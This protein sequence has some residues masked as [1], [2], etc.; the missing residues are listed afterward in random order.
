[1]VAIVILVIIVIIIVLFVKASILIV[2]IIVI[3][4]IIYYQ[5]FVLCALAK[6]GSVE[7]MGN[8]I[9]FIDSMLQLHIICKKKRN[10]VLP[11]GVDSITIDPT[12]NKHAGKV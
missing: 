8:W 9:T 6:R 3:I 5:S 4:F 10:V 12:T 1:M 2:A 11:V 7:W